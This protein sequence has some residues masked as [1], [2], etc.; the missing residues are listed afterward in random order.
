[1]F[2]VYVILPLLPAFEGD[3]GGATG[4][5]IIATTAAVEEYEFFF[6]T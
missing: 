6:G 3:V 4:K 5:S 2:R 1:M